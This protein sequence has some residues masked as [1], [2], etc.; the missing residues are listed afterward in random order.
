MSLTIVRYNMIQ[1]LSFV[2]QQPDVHGAQATPAYHCSPIIISLPS[3]DRTKTLLVLLPWAPFTDPALFVSLSMARAIRSV[4]LS[5]P[6]TPAT[7]LASLAELNVSFQQRALACRAASFLSELPGHSWA[8]AN[9]GMNH[10]RCRNLVRTIIDSQPALPM[11]TC[12]S[13]DQ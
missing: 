8:S 2:D 13:Y 1:H 5:N 7:R 4:G 9:Y 3:S 11:T 10:Q 12:P 6:P